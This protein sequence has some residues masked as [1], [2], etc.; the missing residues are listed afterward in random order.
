MN[1][2]VIADPKLCI[3]C[4]TCMAACSEVHKAQG[5]QQ[6]PRLTVMRHEQ[7]TMPVQ[8][9]HCDDAPCSKVCP[10][11]AIRQTG[12]CVQLNESL[13]IGC[14][15]CAVACP[16]GAIQ[17]SGSR[18]V[19]MATS[20]DTYIPSSIRSSN[21]STSAG[22]R[23]FGEDLLSWE[24]GVRSI[25]V[26]CDL[27]EFRTEGP[28]CVDACPSQALKLVND[29]DTERAAHIRRQQAADTNPQGASAFSALPAS[30]LSTTEGAC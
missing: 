6:A 22:L 28:A 14:N 27:C 1:R 20:Y 10:V 9:R 4:G 23:C 13:C 11:E 15:L 29:S 19:A 26:K 5:L 8:C 2:F 16:F 21:P 17:S 12:D 3:G 24:P 25:A 7:A 18:P 30:D